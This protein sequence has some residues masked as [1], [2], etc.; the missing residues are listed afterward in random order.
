METF[1]LG[2]DNGESEN[3]PAQ[4]QSSSSSSWER[5][6][7]F[8]RKADEAGIDPNQEAE[9]ERLKDEEGIRE[10]LA[11]F[12]SQNYDGL[13][14]DDEMKVSSV[15]VIE[16]EISK[17]INEVEQSMGEDENAEEVL[18]QFEEGVWDSAHE[19][20]IPMPKVR[21]A[22][23]EEIG[24]M[25]DRNIWSIRPIQECW[26]K[27]GKAPVSVRWVIVN[28]GTPDEMII[29]CRLVARD[30]KGGIKIGTICSPKPHPSKQRE[31][32]SA[33]PRHVCQLG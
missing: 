7:R 25:E 31:C 28:K 8:K 20:Y 13:G 17:W 6:D 12:E 18:D 5:P 33:E 27:T 24:F 30:F 1:P 4:G 19:G 22:K 23:G 16:G 14:I 21:E 10:A 26:D 15:E 3:V 11:D 29:R 9:R 2:G 32:W